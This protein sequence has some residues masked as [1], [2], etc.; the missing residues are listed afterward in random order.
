MNL[1]RVS[2]HAAALRT[3]AIACTMAGPACT[4]ASDFFSPTHHPESGF[5]SAGGGAVE[6]GVGRRSAPCR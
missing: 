5:L 6:Q 4:G 3:L 1:D 2:G